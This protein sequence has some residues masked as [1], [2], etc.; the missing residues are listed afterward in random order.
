[1]DFLSFLSWSLL[2]G[3]ALVSRFCDPSCTAKASEGSACNRD[4][5]C[6]SFFNFNLA[7]IAASLSCNVSSSSSSSMPSELIFSPSSNRRVEVYRRFGVVV[8]PLTGDVYLFGC[9]I[10]CWYFRRPLGELRSAALGDLGGQDAAII[11][12]W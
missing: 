2:V 5:D 10:Y 3:V 4:L 9:S 7:S 8:V 12:N 11:R 6:W 1:M